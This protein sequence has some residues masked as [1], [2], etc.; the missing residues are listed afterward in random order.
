MM[1]DAQS[2]SSSMNSDINFFKSL[3]IVYHGIVKYCHRFGILNL[4]KSLENKQEP[5]FETVE[6]SSYPQLMDFIFPQFPLEDRMMTD[7]QLFGFDFLL[8]SGSYSYFFDISTGKMTLLDDFGGGSEPGE[9]GKSKLI[10]DQPLITEEVPIQI[11]NEE[12][13]DF[14]LTVEIPGT[15]PEQEIVDNLDLYSLLE[16]DFSSNVIA[17]SEELTSLLLPKHVEA[18]IQYLQGCNIKM[19]FIINSRIETVKELLNRLN[20]LSTGINGIEGDLLMKDAISNVL[21]NLL[22]KL[23]SYLEKCRNINKYKVPWIHIAGLKGEKATILQSLHPSFVD[24]SIIPFYCDNVDLKDVLEFIK[25]DKLKIKSLKEGLNKMKN[26]NK[27]KSRLKKELLILKA[28]TRR[29]T[30][31]FEICDDFNNLKYSDTGLYYKVLSVLSDFESNM[32]VRESNIKEFYSKMGLPFKSE[33]A[34]DQLKNTEMDDEEELNTLYGIYLSL[35]NGANPLTMEEIESLANANKFSKI[36]YLKEIIQS[37]ERKEEENDVNKKTQES[38]EENIDL[39]NILTSDE[40]ILSSY[41]LYSS[42]AQN[43]L[44]LIEIVEISDYDKTKVLSLLA[45]LN[46][47]LLGENQ[48]NI[49]EKP[50]GGDG[51]GGAGEEEGAVGGVGIENEHLL[52]DEEILNKYLLYRSLVLDKNTPLELYDLIAIP[53]ND[54]KENLMQTLDEAIAMMNKD[55]KGSEKS[56]LPKK[57]TEPSPLPPQEESATGRPKKPSYPLASSILSPSGTTGGADG[58]R[59]PGAR[60]KQLLPK[61]TLK[62]NVVTQQE[63]RL[64]E[65]LLNDLEV[66]TKYLDYSAV[67]QNPLNLEDLVL[68]SNNNKIEL[69]KMLKEAISQANIPPMFP[70]SPLPPAPV[71]PTP[72]PP[73]P[74]PAPLPPAPVPKPLPPAPSQ[75]MSPSVG[76]KIQLKFTNGKLDQ[77]SVDQS[78]LSLSTIQKFSKL[79]QVGCTIESLNELQFLLNVSRAD[80]AHL[81]ALE[82]FVKGPAARCSTNR[83]SCNNCFVC[84]SRK[85]ID[86]DITNMEKVIAALQALVGYCIQNMKK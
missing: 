82:K 27:N 67:A 60:P 9:E 69:I 45:K 36:D 24:S 81:K 20:L 59:D 72:L 55:D 66:Y 53:G 14:L 84:N 41:S 21:S 65:N 46:Q 44:N 33:S 5:R 17:F 16:H 29:N 35:A 8:K 63:L 79:V 52:K 57:L 54:K 23:Q 62:T 4:Y 31:L 74:V 51:P 71:P 18:A 86:K 39:V 11:E 10:S 48:S 56:L 6:W 38:D 47:D 50:G 37:L 13:D 40:E 64:D 1:K 75:P 12:D 85:S 34:I 22:K 76:P 30:L 68:A 77:N 58:R 28:S 73:T 19:L 80:L 25:N 7:Y 3:N 15:T 49:S 26:H 42:I 43:P 83:S 61:P 70:T 32:K 2:G 78:K